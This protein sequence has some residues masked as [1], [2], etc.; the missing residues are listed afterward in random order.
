MGLV[1]VC[2]IM[3]IISTLLQSQALQKVPSGLDFR[4]PSLKHNQ[5]T[6]CRRLPLS[7]TGPSLLSL[8]SSPPH[9]PSGRWR[10]PDV[11]WLRERFAS[12]RTNPLS[13]KR[14]FFLHLAIS[15]RDGIRW[16]STTHPT[17]SLLLPLA[18][19]RLVSAYP[20]RHEF[21]VLASHLMTRECS[22]FP[23]SPLSSPALSH[24]HCMM[25]LKSRES[26]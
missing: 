26:L 9:T 22:S 13:P 15:Y 17:V 7:S 1:C 3:R 5:T 16:L 12:S 6:D 4:S 10:T 23:S 24:P 20:R 14:F 25:N 8:T 18:T 2:R 19:S 21:N 11:E